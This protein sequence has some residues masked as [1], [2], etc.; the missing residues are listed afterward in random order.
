MKKLSFIL[1]LVGLLVVFALPQ[2]SLGKT[3]LD[4]ETPETCRVHSRAGD[5]CPS[6]DTADIDD[7]PLCCVVSAIYRITDWIFFFLMAIVVIMVL[8]GAFSLLTAGGEPDKI[9]RGRNYILWAAVGFIVALLAW[10]VPG[11]AKLIMGL[12]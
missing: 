6:G 2:T 9:A 10:T 1:I 7:H 11:I 12:D 3:N 8:L 4:V 5:V